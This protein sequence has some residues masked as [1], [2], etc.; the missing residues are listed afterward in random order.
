MAGRTDFPQAFRQVL[1]SPLFLSIAGLWLLLLG[2][3]AVRP[4]FFL[5]DDNATWFIGAYAHDFRVLTETGRLAEVNYYQHGGE[6]FLEQGQT[7]VL[8]P[9]VYLGVALAKWVTGDMR[10]SLEWIAAIHLTIGMLGFSFWLRQGGVAPWHA[11]LGGLAWVLNPFVLIVS[12]SWIF[13]SLVAAWLPWLFWTLDH[14]LLRPSARAAFFLGTSASLLFLQ[15]YVQMFAYSVLFLAVYALFQFATRPETRKPAVLYYLGVSVL[16]FTILSL[17]LLLPMLHA[18]NDSAIRASALPVEAALFYN[19]A[20]TD[21]FFA[22]LCLF[23][24]NLAFGASTVILFC[25]AL[26]FIPVTAFRLYYGGAAAQRR[27]FPLLFLAFLALIFSTQWHGLLT[28]LPVFDKFRWPF[29]VFLF[30][31]FFLIA[32]F[33]WT[34]A[35]WT[36]SRFSSARSA[37]LTA[38]ICLTLVVLVN[39]AIS[40]VFHD[41]N[42]F[43]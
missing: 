29:K 10:W 21:F 42:T 35:S 13:T 24:S 39:L 33:A 16:V 43:S 23:Q 26:L 31:D 17:P 9:P 40:L 15:G 5:H 3:E 38:A 22:Q 4:C 14:L 41:K 7:A 37:S 1:R 34:T 32:S 2:M 28:L 8:Y 20:P 19:V 12:A 30:A 36:K 18:V 6:P 25:P 27:L 11:A